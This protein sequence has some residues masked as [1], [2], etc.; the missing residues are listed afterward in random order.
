MT[1]DNQPPQ[2]PRATP[3]TLQRA[4]GPNEAT[5]AHGTPVQPGSRASRQT[6]TQFREA[7]RDET[8][9][10]GGPVPFVGRRREVELLYNAVREGL[11]GH[12][13]RVAWVH[14]V[15]GIGKTRLLAELER[16]VGPERRGVSWYRVSAGPEPGGPPTLSGRTL[17]ALVGGPAVL[18]EADPWLTVQQQLANL[19]GEPAASDCMV[20]VGPLLGLRRADAPE[21]EALR[22]VEA[23]LAVAVQFVGSLY[24]HRGR[25]GP[26]VL[27][28]DGTL[29]RPDELVLF[30]KGLQ[31]ALAQTAAAVMI[32]AVEP[33]AVGLNVTSLGL[34]PLDAESARALARSLAKRLR[35]APTELV[36]NLVQASMGV[37]ERLLDMVRGMVAAGEV[38]SDDGIWCWRARTERGGPLGWQDGLSNLAR[39]N[40]ALPDRI[41]RLPVDLRD[42]VDAAAV[43]GPVLWFGAVLSVLR[44]GRRETSESLSERDRV[45]LKA[46]LM[47][48]QAIDVIG[49]IEH[50]R[51][52]RELEFAFVHPNDPATV[53]AEM[54]EEKRG[55][56]ARLAAQWLDNRPRQDPV[57]DNVRIAELYEQ[58]GRHRQAAQRYL[59]AGNGARTVGQLQRAIALFSA[60]C[61]NAGPDDAD[62]ASDL[63]VAHGGGLMRQGRHREAEQ[64]LLDA[65]YMARCLDDDLRSGVAQLRIAQVA[66][67][68]GRYDAALQFL[69]GAVK[70]LRIAGA[71]RY[72]ADVSDEMGL[73]HLVR[74]DQDAYKNALSHFLKALALRRR[75]EDRRVVA[76]SLCHIARIH[77][78]RGHFLDAMDAVQEAMQICDQIQERWG[79]A[80][81]RMVQGEVLAASGKYKQ[82]LQ[83]WEQA[84]VMATEVGDRGR[85]LELI[86]LQAET[87]IA[88]DDWQHAAALTLDALDTAKEM[89][90]PELLSGIY[91]VQAAIS[92]ERQ[93][94][95]TA[96]LDSERAVQV[97]RE[98]GARMA[99][100][101]AL[102]VRACVLG[103]RALS[104][105]GGRSTV[106]D[107]R[108]TECFEEAL[109]AF[110]DMGDLVRLATGLRSYTAYL[111]QRGGGPRLQAVQS[112]LKETEAE[113]ARV[114]G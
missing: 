61:R 29:G 23:P 3:A 87:Y 60:G 72:I 55:L 10:L 20:V 56:Y 36:D 22:R 107:R 78:G 1:A 80:E 42:V 74:G 12:Q 113:L 91:R 76:R 75:S 102:L 114:A 43:F 90:D 30:V 28:I 27:Q 25:L 73:V 63:R 40:S 9:L 67:H 83:H 2:S 14:G 104:E 62:L 8:T 71:H 49:F 100:A 112:R 24:K 101:R 85:R 97:A 57:A 89:G 51:M 70:H 88:Q 99:V 34:E 41:A 38:I 96:D 84:M 53:V 48:L 79:A 69:D 35:G 93:A 46:A 111:T 66:R 65:L 26:F 7:R 54:D 17:L 109:E 33:P 77:M 44:G 32:D 50:S 21:E 68:S 11:N 103:T 5:P 59:E 108:C 81:A 6:L 82:A 94:L 31:Q 45:A 92:L 95:E 19:V 110:R 52:T 13:T 64:A 106:V 4:P 86:I 98:S 39:T 18:R 15:P 47:Q 105:V 58:G 16:V 37:P